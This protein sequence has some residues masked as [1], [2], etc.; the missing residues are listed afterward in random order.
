MGVSLP[1]HEAGIDLVAVKRNG[2][3]V[4]AL[5]PLRYVRSTTRNMAPD[6]AAEAGIPR[7]RNRSGWRK[8]RTCLVTAALKELGIPRS[9]F[10]GWYRRYK[11][12]CVARLAG[13]HTGAGVHWNRVP[14]TVRRCVVDPADEVRTEAP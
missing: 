14:D 5:A 12:W 1:P 3:H 10:Y 11:D 2:S 7:S 13:R 8:T 4:G 9:T 6:F